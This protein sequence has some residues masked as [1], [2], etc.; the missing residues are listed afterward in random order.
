MAKYILLILAIILFPSIRAAGA[1]PGLIYGKV[2]LNDGKIFEGII[3]WDKN[4]ASWGDV[5]DGLKVLK[6]RRGEEGDDERRGARRIKVLGVTIFETDGDFDW[7][8]SADAHS[9][10]RAGHIK[11]IVPD[12]DEG[13][14]LTLK[15]GIKA[16]MQNSGTDFG[17]DIRE[18][19]VED[20]NEGVVEIYWDEI[21]KIEFEPT[22]K[23]ETSFGKRLYGTA[24]TRRGDTFSGFVCWDMDEVYD[25]DILN[26]QDRR[27]NR[28][29]EFAKIKRI[30]SRTSRSSD[31]TLKDGRELRLEDSNDIDSGNR[32][33]LISDP[34]MGQV[35][36]PWDEFDYIEFQDAPPGPPYESFDG[37]RKIRGTVYTEDGE[38]YTGD[39]RW[40]DDEEYT[41]E[42]INGKYDEISFD[43]EF[44]AIKKIEKISSRSSRVTL[45]DGRSFKLRDSNDVNGENKGIIIYTDQDEVFVDWDDF[46]KM[47]L[48]N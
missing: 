9:G 39:I 48:A 11:T 35:L 26:G 41:W 43:I 10:I 18:F 24:V 27:H 30:E 29:I 1:D 31:V 8:W 4:E 22:P 5:L 16:E 2:Y 28:K 3:R 37:G 33:I 21:E 40:D 12:K 25:A 23:M 20:K 13:A 32:G 34:K 42:M 19:L 44:G 46:E 45:K 6:R 7:N 15:S 14:I 47:E 36:I 38:K 17:N